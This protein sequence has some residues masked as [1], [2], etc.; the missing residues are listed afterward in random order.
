MLDVM[1]FLEL[2]P[3]LSGAHASKKSVLSIVTPSRFDF[4]DWLPGRCLPPDCRFPD[5]TGQ[6]WITDIHSSNKH[7]LKDVSGIRQRV[8]H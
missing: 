1:C 6:A 3:L 5:G 2:W 8:W 7:F 4:N